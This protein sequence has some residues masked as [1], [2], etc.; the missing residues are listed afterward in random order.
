[1]RQKTSTLLSIRLMPS[2]VISPGVSPFRPVQLHFRCDSVC[3]FFRSAWPVA[4]IHL[5]DWTVLAQLRPRFVA[6]RVLRSACLQL[7]FRYPACH[8]HWQSLDSSGTLDA[9][10]LFRSVCV[11]R[12]PPCPPLGTPHIIST[13]MGPEAVLP[14]ISYVESSSEELDRHGLLWSIHRCSCRQALY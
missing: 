13:V 10:T 14:V 7:V 9:S 2:T 3:H 4:Y 1:M 8:C 6:I 11:K 12:R 5:K